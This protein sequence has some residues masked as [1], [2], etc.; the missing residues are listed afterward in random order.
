MQKQRVNVPYACDPPRLRRGI[1]LDCGSNTLSA[2][3]PSDGKEVKTSSDDPV[4]VSRRLSM[5]KTPSCTCREV[6]V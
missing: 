4:P 6:Q 2:Y 5:L 3:W 1:G